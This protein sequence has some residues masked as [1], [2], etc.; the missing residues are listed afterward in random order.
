M[1]PS[2]ALPTCVWPTPTGYCVWYPRPSLSP[3]H[4]TARY[5]RLKPRQWQPRRALTICQTTTCF[6]NLHL[7]ARTMRPSTALPTNL[8]ACSQRILG[9]GPSPLAHRPD[10]HSTT[11]SAIL[12][13]SRQ[14][15][16]VP[17]SPGDYRQMEHTCMP[18]APSGALLP[19]DLG[20]APPPLAPRPDPHD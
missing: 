13:P 14:K 9:V 18:I 16:Y 19:T 15:N 17:A 20:A 2:T 1:R 4:G 3:R 6:D 10:T 11:T 5:S 12:T 7:R 8:F